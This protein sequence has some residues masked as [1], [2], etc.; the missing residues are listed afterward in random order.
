MGT[1]A[2]T[3]LPAL[4]AGQTYAIDSIGF[5]FTQGS[6]VFTGG[7][8]ITVQY[9]GGAAVANTLAAAVLTTAANSVTCRQ[10]IDA[11]ATAAAAIEITNATAPF[12]AGTGASMTVDISY[13]II[14]AY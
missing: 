11:T 8:A 3:L 10:S 1:T 2:V 7:G 9:H 4:P 5:I 6:A 14:G 12:A 13:R